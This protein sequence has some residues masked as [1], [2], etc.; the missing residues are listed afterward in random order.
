MIELSSDICTNFR[1]A[2]SREWLET[3]GM[4]GFACGTVS[5]ALT[6]RYHSILTAATKPPLGR[7]KIAKFE[8]TLKVDG[9]AYELSAN[10][11]PGTVQ[12]TGFQFIRGFRSRSLSD[13]DL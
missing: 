8:E 1:E 5:G 4:G 13:L 2:S 10:H 11:Y 6:R 12:P 9:T 7:I 3:N